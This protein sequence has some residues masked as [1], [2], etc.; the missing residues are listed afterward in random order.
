[1]ANAYVVQTIHH[2][3]YQTEAINHLLTALQQVDYAANDVFHRITQKIQDGRSRINDIN[4]RLITAQQSIQR[5]ETAK[6]KAITIESAA[7]FPDIQRKDYQ[8]LYHDI[9]LTNNEIIA[10]DLLSRQVPELSH[11]SKELGYGCR[12]DKGDVEDL[13]IVCA[14]LQTRHKLA[15]SYDLE[16]TTPEELGNIPESTYAVNDLMLFNA[17]HCPYKQHL[18]FDNLKG[19]EFRESMRK[20][21]S[22]REIQEAPKGLT[23]NLR[24]VEPD[25]YR[26]KPDSIVAA[27]LTVAQNLNLPSIAT[28]AVNR[29]EEAE[30][31]QLPS[32]MYQKQGKIDAIEEVEETAFSEEEET[33]E[34]EEKNLDTIAPMDRLFKKQRTL[35]EKKIRALKE[36]EGEDEM[37]NKTVTT[38]TY[39]AKSSRS[40]STKQPASNEKSSSSSSKPAEKKSDIPEAPPVDMIIKRTWTKEMTKAL[41]DGVSMSNIL[42]GKLESPA[43]TKTV[44]DVATKGAEKKEEGEKATPSLA[45]PD[46]GLIL[47]NN[48]PKGGDAGAV[49]EV[50]EEKKEEA[51]PSSGGGGGG[52]SALLSQ[53]NCDDPLA[54]LRKM[55][56]ERKKKAPAATSAKKKPEPKKTKPVKKASIKKP[57]PKKPEVKKA[58][59]LDLPAIGGKQIS[60]AQVHEE[61]EEKKEEVKQEANDDNREMVAS[62]GDD[63]AENEQDEQE[64]EEEADETPAPMQNQMD[65]LKEAIRLRFQKINKREAEESASSS[66]SDEE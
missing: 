8:S 42:S 20:K 11:G 35:H 51:E 18:T 19:D 31:E 41:Y 46:M 15:Q 38:S 55:A 52:R 49:K 44:D 37:E 63:E 10:N 34:A 29:K 45:A 4:T 14:A 28:L 47:G 24:S 33:P 65:L 3:N 53:L 59:K 43:T 26:Y 60:I 58:P 6:D 25:R 54:R 64:V 5:F 21:K 9:T 62:D 1:M 56:A 13:S 39:Q 48:A 32:E 50:E 66:G 12:G 2:D 40:M 22:I 27:P 61:E 23:G 30:E 17:E 16:Y 7:K 57:E 36:L